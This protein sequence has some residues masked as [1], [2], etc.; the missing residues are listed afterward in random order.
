MTVGE[1]AGTVPRAAA[2][3]AAPLHRCVALTAGTEAAA[4][5]KVGRCRLTAG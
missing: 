1:M 3:L 5:L 4:L 2:A